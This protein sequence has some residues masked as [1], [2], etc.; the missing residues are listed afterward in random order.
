[1]VALAYQSLSELQRQRGDLAGATSSCKQ[2]LELIRKAENPLDTIHANLLHALAVLYRQQGQLEAA[3]KLLGSALEIDHG[4][5]GEEGTGHLA[6]IRE[7]AQIEAARGEDA[8]AFNHFQ[9]VLTLLDKQAGVFAYLPPSPSRDAFLVRPWHLLE[10]LLTLALRLPDAAEQLLSGVLRWKNL[11]PADIAPGERQ[12]LRRL[13]PAY[14]RE[15]D[16]LFDLSIQIANRL[17]KGAGPEGLQMHHELLRRWEAD[18]QDLERRLAEV[19]PVLAQL[20]ALRAVDLPGLRKA[21]PE[22]TIFIELV[23]FC[24]RD[25]AEVC[26]GRDGLLPERYL[27]FVLHALEENVVLCDLGQAADLEGSG[28][29]KVLNSALARHLAGRRQLIVATDRCLRHACT[30]VWG[31][32][33]LVRTLISGRE[34]VSPLLAPSGDLACLDAPPPGRMT[35]HANSLSCADSH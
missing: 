32:Q 11:R 4:S 5:T 14:A 9:R 6:S 10:S 27:G 2:A 13:H 8:N 3:A 23:R 18:R 24:P 7:L 12:Q 15:V 33:N 1:M 20:R 28:G 21:L 34:I 29:A 35:R 26:A 30:Q 22:G 25:F 19:V 31:S 17:I 16:R